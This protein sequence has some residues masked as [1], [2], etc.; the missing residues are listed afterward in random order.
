MHICFLSKE[1]PKTLKAHGGIGT[2]N[3]IPSDIVEGSELNFA[4]FPNIT[5]YKKVFRLHGGHHFFAH[6]E[7]RKVNKWKAYQEKKPFKKADTYLA[8]SDYLGF[9]TK[10]IKQNINYTTI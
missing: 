8:V 10:K 3:E 2:N 9:K 6:E 4:F 1:Y 7:Q 5:P